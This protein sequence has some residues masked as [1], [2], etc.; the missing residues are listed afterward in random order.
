MWSSQPA[1]S[2]RAQTIRAQSRRGQQD[3]V[4]DLSR[5]PHSCR[6]DT[7]NTRARRKPSLHLHRLRPEASTD[8]DDSD[9][10]LPSS[11]DS[12]IF[13][14][15]IAPSM[16]IQFP[17]PCCCRLL[18]RIGDLNTEL[19][20]W[21]SETNTKQGQ[22]E[23]HF[24]TGAPR[25]RLRHLHP[26]VWRRL[27]TSI[28]TSATLLSVSWHAMKAIVTRRSQ[29]PELLGHEPRVAQTVRG[30]Q[31]LGPWQPILWPHQA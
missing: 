18:V 14:P 10:C 9:R 11:E 30:R 15:S 28:G 21:Q 7:G 27:A 25:I 23:W 16:A 19:A 6:R 3:L 5:S 13:A 22:V 8:R 26:S 17:P 1:L 4:A 12:G 20:A 31:G 29:R 24:T 2:R